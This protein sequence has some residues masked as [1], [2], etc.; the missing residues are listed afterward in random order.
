M[1]PLLSLALVAVLGIC[2]TLLC[3]VGA[4]FFL[5]ARRAAVTAVLATV[6][7]GVGI[8]LSAIAAVPFV[9]IGQS[10]HSRSAVIAY[11]GALAFGG[12]VGGIA[13]VSFYLRH[14]ANRAEHAI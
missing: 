5:P 6:G 2:A 11:F 1:G 7:G 12:V 8:V 9:G 10:L 13:A 14:K 4:I 3:F